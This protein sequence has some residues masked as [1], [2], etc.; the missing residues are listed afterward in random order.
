MMD[1]RLNLALK[2]L[3]KAGKLRSNELVRRLEDKGPMARQ[4]AINTIKEGVS[5]HKISEK[6]Q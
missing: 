6:K 4:T 1:W 5:K 3:E 2:I